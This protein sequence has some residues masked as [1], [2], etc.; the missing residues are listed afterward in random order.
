[1]D[2]RFT[3][4]RSARNPKARI[5]IMKGHFATSNSHLNTYI[6]MSTVKTR[7]NNSREAAKE[8]ANEYLTNTMVNTI[9]CLDETEVIGTFMAEHLADSSNLSLSA[10]NNI[11]V[12]TPEFDTL[13]Q[14]MFRDNKQRMIQNQ[15]V[16]IL[17][18]SVTTGKTI[19]RAI[20]SILYYGGTVCGICSIFSAVS[21]IAGM[22]IKTIFT[23]KDLPDYR[24]YDAGDCPLCREGKRVEALV[25][26]YGYSKL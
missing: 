7:H 24:A 15:Q 11:S 9:V 12:I 3:D 16:I 25:N 4:L 21:K 13:G 5:K 18:A 8:L 2:S 26:S 17:A 20:D 1:M 23:S 6:D 22:E 14:I 19:H 10:G